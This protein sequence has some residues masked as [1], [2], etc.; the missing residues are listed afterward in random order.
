[1]NRVWVCSWNWCCFNNKVV[2]LVEASSYNRFILVSETTDCMEQP[3]WNLTKV[4]EITISVEWKLMC[5]LST[6]IYLQEIF[7]IANVSM[8]LAEG[9]LTQNHHFINTP[10][11][12]D[13]RNCRNYTECSFKVSFN[14]W[15]D[16]VLREICYK[17]SSHNSELSTKS[18]SDHMI[19]ILVATLLSS[20]TQLFPAHTC[21]K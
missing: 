6:D 16:N 15:D 9:Y 19:L 17:G 20:K 13:R 7:S 21:L 12:K 2:T 14:T 10:F 18:K 8:E 11:K 3:V 5:T 1:M 4:M